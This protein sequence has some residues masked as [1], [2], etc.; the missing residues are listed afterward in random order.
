VT[1]LGDF[2]PIGR[3][4]LWGVFLYDRS[5]PDVCVTLHLSR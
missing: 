1:R 3:M 2:S 4:P 5:S